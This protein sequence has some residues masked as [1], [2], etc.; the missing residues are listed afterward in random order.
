MS[1]ANDIWN[2]VCDG[3]GAGEGDKMLG[4]VLVMDGSI[5]NGGMANALVDMLD[6]AEVAAGVEGL[7]YFGLN[8]AADLVVE[9]HQ[10][11]K[12]GADV[13]ELEETRD[14]DYYELCDTDVI[15]EAFEKKLAEEP[16][17]FAPL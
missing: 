13:A 8:A 2:R 11:I 5:Q 7:R 14:A 16:S 1:N 12:N 3:D 6:D 17:G 9:I 4:A 15:M 10:A